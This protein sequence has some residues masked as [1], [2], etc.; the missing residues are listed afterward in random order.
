[1]DKLQ[2][3]CKQ[4][5]NIE[6]HNVIKIGRRYYQASPELIAIKEKITSRD[7]YSLGLPLGEE[8]NQFMPTPALLEMLAKNSLRKAYINQKGSWKRR[9]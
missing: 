9:L 1:M 5:N 3:F 4:F 8:K 6:L 7:V 2:A